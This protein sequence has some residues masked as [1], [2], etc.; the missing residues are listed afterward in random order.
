MAGEDP[1]AVAN[2]LFRDFL[3]P[4][5]LGG[6]VTPGRPIGARSALELFDPHL[7]DL[8]RVRDVERARVRVA[9]ELAPVDRV[10]RPTQAEWA[11]AA[12][13]HDLVQATHPGFHAILRRAGPA[14]LLAL[15]HQTLDRVP[16]PASIG[17][18]LARH[19]W[20]ARMFD[21]IRT[22]TVVKW[23][24][25]S[26][27]FLGREPPARLSAWPDLRR[28]RVD[29]R[30]RDLMQVVDAGAVVDAPQFASSV[31][32]FLSKTPL[33]DLA[34][35]D[36]TAP[37]FAF[38]A[39]SLGLIANPAGRTLATR[40]LDRARARRGGIDTALGRATR[41][42][43]AERAW[44]SALVAIDLLAERALSD[45]VVASWVGSAVPV[46]ASVS[47]GDAAD[48]AG[49]ARGVGA[50]AAVQK[51]RSDEGGFRAVIQAELLARLEPLAGTPAVRA[52]V[53]AL[54]AA[55]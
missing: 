37:A 47:E 45:A 53:G 17:Q 26:R 51:L 20:F 40:A 18:A 36:R 5:V 28:V 16:A 9:R 43:V 29:K 22:D 13:L 31:T 23:W 44:R 35:C 25:G 30:S 34:T 1:R 32:R 3:A 24:V 19:T 48:D 8:D 50:W 55:G 38:R 39:E 33:T 2:R 12:S 14:R 49:F 52:L 54:A 42:L 4:L 21:M 11:L 6:E 46:A 15:V 10:E 7:L 27:T 41:V